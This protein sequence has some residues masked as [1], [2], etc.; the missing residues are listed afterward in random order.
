MPPLMILGIKAN[1]CLAGWTL[2]TFEAL[3]ED[4][5]EEEE[6]MLEAAIKLLD[7]LLVVVVVG[8]LDFIS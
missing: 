6:D 2:T 3:F 7:E 5:F 4:K 8:S 1:C